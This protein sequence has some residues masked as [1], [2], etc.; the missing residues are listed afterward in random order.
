MLIFGII[1]QDVI[2]HPPFL[3]KGISSIIL[4]LKLT[5][6]TCLVSELQGVPAVLSGILNMYQ[7]SVD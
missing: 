7:S 5:R 4:Y 6:E 1:P 2:H 3:K